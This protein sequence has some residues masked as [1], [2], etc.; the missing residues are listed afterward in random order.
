MK[1]GKQI[2]YTS[3]EDYEKGANLVI[4]NL[5]SLHKNEKE[6]GDFLYYLE[7]TNEYV[8]VSVDGYIRTYF[9]P[10]RGK[11]YFDSK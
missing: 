6:D 7:E 5:K 9:K 10:D 3:K 4:S 1:H 2:G 11:S 8:V